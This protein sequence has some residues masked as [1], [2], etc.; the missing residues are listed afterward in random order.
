VKTFS[1][2]DLDDVWIRTEMKPGDLGAIV[3]L[4]GTLYAKEYG[5]DTTFETYVARPLCDFVLQP[6][7]RQKIWL[8][9]RE[10]SLRGCI[11]IVESTPEVAQLRWFLL[12]P[13]IR[14]LGLGRYLVGEAVKH[15]RSEGFSE[16]F[17]WTLESLRAALKLYR[18]QG[19]SLVEEDRH[20]IWGQTV[21]EQKYAMSLRKPVA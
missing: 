13:D 5:F 19:F 17:L 14:G 18:E 6:S 8:V 11:A 1:E 7:K 3:H 15:C 21:T 2:K 12:H 9:E 10:Q 16:V 4:H 20:V